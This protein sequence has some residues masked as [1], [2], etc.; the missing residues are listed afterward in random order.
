[1]KSDPEPPSKLSPLAKYLTKYLIQCVIH[2][3]LKHTLEP[4]V[5]Y[6]VGLVKKMCR[7]LYN[8]FFPSSG[9]DDSQ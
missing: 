1:M 8:F 7:A 9:D 2:I 3:L 4:L 5:I 6:L